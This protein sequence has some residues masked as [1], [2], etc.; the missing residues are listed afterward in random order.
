MLSEYSPFKPS[1][2]ARAVAYNPPNED[3]VF[4][5]LS[6][7]LQVYETSQTHDPKIVK[8][9]TDSWSEIIRFSPDGKFLAIALQ[10]GKLIITDSDVYETVL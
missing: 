10:N 3:L 7:E 4:M 2:Q 8:K 5:T 6:G 9:L 1:Q